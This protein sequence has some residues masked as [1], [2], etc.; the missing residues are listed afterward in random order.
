MS[1]AGDGHT[2]DCRNRGCQGGG[3]FDAAPPSWFEERG[4][5][6][7]TNC[8]SCRAWKNEQADEDVSCS[9]CGFRWRVPKAVKVM[10]HTNEGPWTRPS[11]CTRCSA[12]PAWRRRAERRRQRVRIRRTKDG[13][14][15]GLSV[16]DRSA[17]LVAELEGALA[18]KGVTTTRT[19]RVVI[20][21]DIKSYQGVTRTVKSY[22][23]F[24]K[25][26]G[27]YETLY[28]HILFREQSGGH[29]DGLAA[30][31]RVAA[32]VEVV[33]KLA[34]LANNV[35]SDEAF[36]FESGSPTHTLVKVDRQ[37]GVFVSIA[38]RPRMIGNRQ[39]VVPRTAFLPD[40]PS[41]LAKQVQSGR[42]RPA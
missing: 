15:R 40:K 12:D 35:N 37:T 14:R 5:S 21:S 23:S 4:L 26:D 29:F 3:T 7:P 17:S 25:T 33:Y 30:A 22:Q 13:D 27:K 8:P 19:T 24:T 2:Y 31:F 11:L 6:N 34:A 28:E 10:V 36:Q 39:V 38:T 1:A 16:L 18:A 20:P 32:D 41:Y 42:W 9:A